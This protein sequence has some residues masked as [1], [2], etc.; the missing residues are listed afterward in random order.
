[1]AFVNVS[2]I[3]IS[4]SPKVE[5]WASST[6]KTILLLEISS[7]SLLFNPSS[8]LFMLLIFWIDVTIKVFAGSLLFNLVI[9]TP[10]FSVACTS[11]LASAK[12]LYSCND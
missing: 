9:K 7:I 3:V 10:V 1:M 4:I 6:I 12:A 11:S 8:S 5:R 2:F